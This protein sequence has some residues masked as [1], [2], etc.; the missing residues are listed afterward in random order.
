M[1][2]CQQLR[3]ISTR[4]LQQRLDGLLRL[5]SVY[6]DK[7]DEHARRNPKT[8]GLPPRPPKLVLHLWEGELFVNDG[9]EAIETDA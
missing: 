9:A 7:L 6:A 2:L 4:E 8:R 3:R 1:Q 5:D